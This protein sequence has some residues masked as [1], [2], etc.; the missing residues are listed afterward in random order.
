V[1]SKKNCI[2][3]DYLVDFT[4]FQ[5]SY[6]FFLIIHRAK[7][8]IE[9][10]FNYKD[11]CHQSWPTILRIQSNYFAVGHSI[12]QLFDML[13]GMSGKRRNTS[14]RRSSVRAL[15]V[16]GAGSGG[17]GGEGGWWDAMAVKCSCGFRLQSGRWGESFVHCFSF[18]SSREISLEQGPVFTQKIP[19]ARAQ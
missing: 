14:R 16:V 11:N 18:Y 17:G 15:M 3:P 8:M 5:N 12:L 13:L 6:N 9:H 4:V 2:I 19:R 10:F 1:P 7:N